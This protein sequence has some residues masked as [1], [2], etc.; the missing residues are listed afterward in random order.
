MRAAP[1][2]CLLAAL[3]GAGVLVSAC[4]DDGGEG[5]DDVAGTQGEDVGN[6]SGVGTECEGGQVPCGAECVDRYEPT[7]DVVFEQVLQ[8]CVFQACHGDAQPQENLVV[9]TPAQAHMNMVDVASV[10]D[11][12]RVL[13]APGS[14][15]QSYLVAKLRGEDITETSTS[16]APGQQMPI[17]APPLC[18]ARILL[19]EDWVAAGAPAN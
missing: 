14:P 17:G 7:L 3:F 18:E 1:A 8:G 13:V 9:T 12:D 11:P 10:Q 15:A 4:A 2:G 16:G 5:D 19:V 6:D